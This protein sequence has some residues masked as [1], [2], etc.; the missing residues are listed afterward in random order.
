VKVELLVKEGPMAGASFNFDEPDRF[1][2]GRSN[3]AQCSLPKDPFVSNHHFLIEVSPGKVSLHELGSKN[4]TFVNGVRYGGRK[5]PAAGVEQ[6]PPD[7]GDVHLQDG[8]RISVGDTLIV[9]SI[10]SISRSSKTVTFQQPPDGSRSGAAAGGSAGSGESRTS[11]PKPPPGGE[12]AARQGRESLQELLAEARAAGNG[13][14]LPNFEVVRLLGEG[15]MGKVFL[16][17]DTRDGREVAIKVVHPRGG[18]D[19]Q[20]VDLF[21]RE[22]DLT[23]QLRH[24]NVVRYLDGGCVRGVFFLVLEFVDGFDLASLYEQHGGPVPLPVIG[25]LMVDALRGLGHAHTVELEAEIP[26]PRTGKRVRRKFSGLVHR[27]LKPEN[28]L[29]AKRP[30]GVLV[31][32]IADLGLAKVYGSAGLSDFTAPDAI[33]GTPLYWPRE[34]LAD[35][36]YLKPASDVFAMGTILYYFLSGHLPRAGLES[37]GLTFHRLCG[38]ILREPVVPIRTYLPRLHPAV[39]EVIDTALCD[40]ISNR[41]AEAGIMSAALRRALGKAG[42]QVRTP[43]RRPPRRDGG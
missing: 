13:P 12:A 20:V 7:C 22:S 11:P 35:Y 28:I 21:R 6:A 24:P 23:R 2:F 16:A 33:A 27:D 1:L 32:K 9:V 15:G 10:P 29:V 8:D 40:E 37:K 17:K 41:Y 18:V 4:G 14:R 34:Q 36:R 43:R 38:V 39:A 31:P 30:R 25:P 3:E 19:D 26:D 42:V 5:P